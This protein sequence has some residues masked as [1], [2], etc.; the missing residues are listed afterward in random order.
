MAK[1]FQRRFPP[2][3]AGLL[4]GLAAVMVIL[5]GKRMMAPEFADVQDSRELLYLATGGKIRLQL[6]EEPGRILAWGFP[7]RLAV[8]RKRADSST[9]TVVR[10]AYKELVEP[11]TLIGPLEEPGEYS[12][13]AQLHVCRFPGEKYCARIQLDQTVIVESGQELPVEVSLRVDIGAVAER[14]AEAGERNQD[15]PT[16]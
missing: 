4:L 13:I 15:L 6:G 1:V 3:L 2:Y 9:E 5:Q 10:M 14:A 16:P 12:L 7:T 8:G 11:E